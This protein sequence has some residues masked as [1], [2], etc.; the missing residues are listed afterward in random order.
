LKTL[1]GEYDAAIHSYETAASL[2]DPNALASLEHKLG[3]VH[4]RLGKWQL[5]ECYF[6][7][8]L[9]YLGKSDDPARRASLLADQSLT[10]YRCGESERAQGLARQAL[11]LAEGSED[12][13]AL[14]QAHNMLGM[15]ARAR[16]NFEAALTELGDSLQIARELDDL[17]AQAAAL[18]NLALVHGERGE[19]DQALQMAE[20]ALG[21]CARRGDRHREAALL[22][23]LADL[24]HSAGR[25]PEAMEYLRQ[26]VAIFA[27]IGQQAGEQDPEIWKLSEW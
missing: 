1:A 27:E 11:D 16:R 25:E 7:V 8:A 9:E 17:G 18:N 10:A 24:L 12:L 4:L 22:N 23:N 19:L 21:L 26:A 20:A 14:A 3:E 2:C 5:A 13:R 6:Q 15:L